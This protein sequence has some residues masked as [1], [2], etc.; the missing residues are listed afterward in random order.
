MNKIKYLISSLGFL[1]LSCQSSD[2]KE[3]Q[4]EIKA[5]EK[6]TVLTAY[7]D[8]A[9]FDFS[10]FQIGKGEL[11][12][13]KIGMTISEAE[14]QFSGLSKKVG[15][16]TDFGFGGGSPAYLYY[17]KDDVLFALIPTLDTDTTLFIIAAGKDFKT[18]NGL[19]PKSYVSELI[20]K[21]PE[22]EVEQDLMNGWEYFSDTAN[23]W[24]FV[25]MTD[26]ETQI[27]E[28]LELEVPSKPKRLN[29]KADWITIR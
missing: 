12:N 27:G 20:G 29:T 26:E 18:T 4:A 5:V 21:Y 15:Q 9:E 13:I 17:L 22:L 16:A 28:Y 19:N 1:L 6:Q 10:N 8:S 3:A 24:D 14:K 25:F 23:K 11:G 2:T 7:N